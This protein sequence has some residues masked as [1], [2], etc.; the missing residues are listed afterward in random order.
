M[1]RLDTIFRQ[2]EGSSIVVNAHR[3]LHGE[4]L[5]PDPPGSGVQGQFYFTRARNADRAHDMIVK[6]ASER[7]P[8]VYGFD[9]STEIQVLCPMHKG[10]AGTEAFNRALQTIYTGNAP[11][12]ELP[13]GPGQLPRTFRV[14]DR[15]MQT[16]NDYGRAVFN[17]DIGTVTE[18]DQDAQTLT[19]AIDGAEVAYEGKEIA[20]LKLAYAIS[21]HKSQGS[22]FPAVLIPLL[23]EHRVMLR[24]N[25]LYTAMTRARSLCLVVGD[26]RAVERAIER[27]DAAHRFTGLRGRTESA[28]AHALGGVVY[29]RDASPG[30]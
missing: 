3:V 26:P 29:E 10:R 2:S 16:R 11:S 28:F 17:G 9:S 27:A 5:L 20:Q 30:V 4:S 1:V 15:V 18:V 6:L 25:L 19:V 14:G 8:Q 13:P 7:I 21:I 23:A 24:R 22:E 12:L